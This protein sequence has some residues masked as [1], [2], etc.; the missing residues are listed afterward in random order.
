VTVRHAGVSSYRPAT[1]KAVAWSS[2]GGYTVAGTGLNGVNLTW[3]CWAKMTVD[4]VAYATPMSCDASATTYYSSTF[5]S[6]REFRQE[7]NTITTRSLFNLVVGTWYFIAFVHRTTGVAD[8]Y[9][10]PAGGSIS[11]VNRASGSVGPVAS[12]TM[13]LGVDRFSSWLNGSIAAVKIW[14]STA[15]TQAQLLTESATYAATITS[16]LWAN[17]RFDNGPSTTD[18]GASA[19]TLTATGAAGTTDNSGPPIT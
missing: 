6:L 19:R 1:S 2:N 12:S 4:R 3:C 17:Y 11:T 9:W 13:R 5:D 18:S 15:L 8:M 14:T 16:N 10:M 7:T